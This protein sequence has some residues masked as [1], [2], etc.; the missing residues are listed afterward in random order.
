MIRLSI[1]W[2]PPSIN[3]AYINQRGGGRALSE[4]TRRFKTEAPA[5]LLR[6]H[7]QEMLFFV[8]KKNTPLTLAICCW[9]TELE[10][11]GWLAFLE[12]RSKKAVARYKKLDTTNRIK[13]LEDVVAMAAGVDDSQNFTVALCKRLGQTEKTDIWV[14]DPG[15]EYSPFD[16]AFAQLIG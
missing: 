2:I 16:A 15:K 10:N 3:E 1:P 8:D 13:I 11:K 7:R 12:G 5:H 4:V 6:Y 9:M 14:W